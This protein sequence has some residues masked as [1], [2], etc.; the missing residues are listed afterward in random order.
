MLIGQR[1]ETPNLRSPSNGNQTPQ[2]NIYLCKSSG[3]RSVCDR[4]Q[5]LNASD[6]RSRLL[7]HYVVLFE[8]LNRLKNPMFLDHFFQFVAIGVGCFACFFPF[9]PISSTHRFFPRPARHALP[10]QG[11]PPRVPASLES[12]IGLKSLRF[13]IASKNL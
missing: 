12:Q 4:L 5:S 9:A 8:S 10:L 2:K 13:E 11:H 7:V 3:D 6:L 1:L